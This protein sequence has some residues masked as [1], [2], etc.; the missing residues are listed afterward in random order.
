MQSAQIGG[1]YKSKRLEDP[2]SRKGGS[3]EV[4][5]GNNTANYFLDD[6]TLRSGSAELLSLNNG[7][8]ARVVDKNGTVR[9]NKAKRKGG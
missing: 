5:S 4:I 1:L 7:N 6:R 8:G 2:S 3:L 9:Y